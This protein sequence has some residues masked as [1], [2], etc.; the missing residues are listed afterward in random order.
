M[1]WGHALKHTHGQAS[2][3]ADWFLII[4]Q[5]ECESTHGPQSFNP[6]LIDFLMLWRHYAARVYLQDW[7]AVSSVKNMQLYIFVLFWDSL[8]G[9]ILVILHS[10][11]PPVLLSL[12]NQKADCVKQAWE[13]SSLPQKHAWRLRENMHKSLNESLLHSAAQASIASLM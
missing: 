13:A 1:R 5:E 8:Q 3:F 10:L 11:P 9:L 7:Q 4:L 6:F 12:R 2:Q